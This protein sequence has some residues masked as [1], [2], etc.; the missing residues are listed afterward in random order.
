LRNPGLDSGRCPLR[1]EEEDAG[2]ILLKCP[3]TRRLR[4]HLLSRKWQTI[5][6]EI[7]YKNTINCTDTER[8][9]GY[10]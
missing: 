1:N 3:Q 9:K 10:R 8:N 2:H 7:A 5:N 4:E 6:E